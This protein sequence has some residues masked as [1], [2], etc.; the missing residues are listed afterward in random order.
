VNRTGK[1]IVVLLAVALLAS[2]C[3]RFARRGSF[4]PEAASSSRAP[5]AYGGSV[6]QAP[7]A[8]RTLAKTGT[9]RIRVIDTTNRVIAGA[10]V[11][12]KGPKDGKAITDAKG[13]AKATVPS[14][15]YEADIAPC[16]SR[17]V[18]KDYR[19]AQVFVPRGGTAGGD[20]DGIRWERRYQPTPSVKAQP[21]APWKVGADFEIAIRIED[22]CSFEAAKGASI[23][24]YAW[25]LSDTFV[26]T[27]KPT[28]KAGADGFAHA[29]VTCK[30]EGNGTIELVDRT[31]PKNRVEATSALSVP[32]DGQFCEA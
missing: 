11:R 3:G 16:G 1:T 29:K 31:F 10:I 21:D 15:T 13:I 2:G 20:L 5:A 27:A 23:P 17:V 9:L 4:D 22:R 14:G 7:T 26:L 12:Y 30:A 6:S 32:D 8:K 19:S 28:M 24:E 18:T 25:V